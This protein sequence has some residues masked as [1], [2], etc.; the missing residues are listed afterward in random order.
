MRDVGSW[1]ASCLHPQPLPQDV[2]VERL[3][4]GQAL[5]GALEDGDL[6]VAVHPFDAEHRLGVQLTGGTFADIVRSSRPP[7]AALALSEY[8]LPGQAPSS[9]CVTACGSSSRCAGRRAC[10]RPAGRRG[11][12]HEP[13]AP[14]Q[15]QLMR[16]GRL[17]DPDRAGDV[18]D[19]ELAARQRIEN[20][21]PGRVA[22]HPERL[23]KR[24][25]ASGRVRSRCRRSAASASGRCRWGC[26][27]SQSFDISEYMSKLLI[28]TLANGWTGGK[29][30]N[31]ARTVVCLDTFF[32]QSVP[33]KFGRNWLTAYTLHACNQRGLTARRPG[34]RLVAAPVDA[35]RCTRSSSG[36]ICDRGPT[37]HETLRPRHGRR[38][39][40]LQRGTRRNPRLSRAER[41]RQDDDDADPHRL[42]A[43]D[44]RTRDV[45]GF[46]VFT[47]PVEAKRAPATCRKRRRSTR[48]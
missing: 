3:E 22:E 20:P 34:A 17:A 43:A 47:H 18:A 30:N 27:S 12:P 13:H 31:A 10:R 37:H 2:G 25:D 48:T 9:T 26:G 29:R 41:R 6:L 15:P 19:A 33:C 39:R 35:A 45:A 11:G 42:H 36:E 32:A 16:D 14:Q 44:G 24:L 5:Q 8:R 1:A 7:P 4:P 28:Y 21:D 46:D 38:R 40:Q 23:G